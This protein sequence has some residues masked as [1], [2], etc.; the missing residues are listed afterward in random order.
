MQEYFAAKGSRS[1]EDKIYANLG[2]FY[3]AKLRYDDAAKTYKAFALNL[4]H[5][6][7]P[8]FGMRVVEIYGKGNFPKLVLEAKKDFASKYGLQSEY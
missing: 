4:F 7:S 8:H 2:E 6:S 5:R 3:L 1:Y